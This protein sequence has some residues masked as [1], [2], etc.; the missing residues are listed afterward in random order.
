MDI[1]IR[2]LGVSIDGVAFVHDV[3]RAI[4]ELRERALQVLATA[5]LGS[6]LALACA[7]H[8]DQRSCAPVLH[9]PD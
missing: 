2:T 3:P 6:L 1:H 8:L 9:W 4:P 7:S 5:S